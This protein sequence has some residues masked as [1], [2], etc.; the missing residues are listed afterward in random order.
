MLKLVIQDDEGKTTIVPLIRDEV[1]IG[2][3]DGNTIRLTERNVSRSHARIARE[4]SNITIEDLSSYN[5]VRVNGS[6][7]KGACSLNV[8][9]RVR[10]GDYLIELKKEDTDGDDVNAIPSVVNDN[11]STVKM[12]TISATAAADVF[13]TNEQTALTAKAK[14]TAKKTSPLGPVAS[15]SEP[16]RKVETKPARLVVLSHNLTQRVFP[17]RG[18]AVTVGRTEENEIQI[19]HRSIS[20]NHC[21]ILLKNNRYIIEDLGSANGL[22]IN[23]EEYDRVELRKG[24]IVELGHVRVRFV[25]AG[26]SFEPPAVLAEPEAEKKR[27]SLLPWAVG[28]GLAAAVVLMLLRGMGGSSDKEEV[29][30]SSVATVYQDAGTELIDPAAS[31]VDSLLASANTYMTE[32][33]WTLAK[34]KLQSVLEIEPENAEAKKWLAQI[35]RKLVAEDQLNGIE[36]AIEA[37]N[38]KSLSGLVAKIEDPQLKQLAQKRVDDEEGVWR[39]KIES[40]ANSAVSRKQCKP[41][42]KKL[43]RDFSAQLSAWPKLGAP[44]TT[45]TKSCKRNETLVAS[46]SSSSVATQAASSSSRSAA[47]SSVAPPVVDLKQQIRTASQE[48]KFKTAI[49]LCSK[50]KGLNDNLNYVCSSAGCSLKNKS[51]A[52]KYYKRIKAE[53]YKKHARNNCGLELVPKA[54]VEIPPPTTTNP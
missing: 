41:A 3:E 14:S 25:E 39:T 36:S 54:P 52:L 16:T 44:I 47:S 34:E 6:K 50:A 31:K 27:S 29:V 18:K 5:G 11:D 42:I 22:H 32:K 38:F 20:R 30:S 1:T 37:K 35:D 33:D 24:D 2:R 28:L 53:H 48:G 17:I 4:S 43:R 13:D 45:A 23:G 49:S 19:D 26:E 40:A 51:V 12:E 7:I 9:D 8:S 46:N 10:I 21:K 15:P